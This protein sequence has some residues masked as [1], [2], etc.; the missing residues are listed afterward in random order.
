MSIVSQKLLKC[1]KYIR[2]DKFCNTGYKG[3]YKGET[4]DDK[5]RFKIQ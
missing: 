1:V 2:W 5:E 4:A 3:L